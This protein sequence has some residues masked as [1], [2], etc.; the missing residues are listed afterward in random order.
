MTNSVRACVSEDSCNKHLLSCFVHR[1]L[2][3]WPAWSVRLLWIY[4]PEK[5]FIKSDEQQSHPGVTR[6]CQESNKAGRPLI[7]PLPFGICAA[8]IHKVLLWHIFH[9]QEMWGNFR[10]G[11]DG[12]LPLPRLLDSLI[13]CTVQIRLPRGG[14]SFRDC[15]HKDVQITA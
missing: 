15:V 10:L 2:P 7:I 5:R 9:D 14:F 11:H 1:L 12:Y 4:H 3:I 13:S 6:N 8:I